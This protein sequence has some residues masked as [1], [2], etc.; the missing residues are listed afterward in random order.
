LIVAQPPI[1]IDQENVTMARPFNKKINAERLAF[2]KKCRTIADSIADLPIMG[3]RLTDAER[4]AVTALLRGDRAI[5]IILDE[6]P[7]TVGANTTAGKCG[8]SWQWKLRQARNAPG[9]FDL[10]AEDNDKYQAFLE[11]GQRIRAG[12]A[13]PDDTE[14][15]DAWEAREDEVRAIGAGDSVQSL[16]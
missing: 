12:K 7:A 1:I 14:A 9:F 15:L 5:F 16:G 2:E 10:L 6:R 4:R 13:E 8:T 11:A 3:E